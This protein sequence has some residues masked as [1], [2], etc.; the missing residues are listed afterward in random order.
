[1][2]SIDIQQDKCEYCLQEKPPHPDCIKEIATEY[3]IQIDQGLP[4]KIS[5][6]LWKN[7]IRKI[8]YFYLIFNPPGRMHDKE[9]S[10]AFHR[11]I[12]MGKDYR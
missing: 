7:H 5:N 9:I 10:S 8:T 2:I 1:M 11:K 6:Y 12:Y 3:T 4:A